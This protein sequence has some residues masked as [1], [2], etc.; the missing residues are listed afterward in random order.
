MINSD[1]CLALAFAAHGPIY[2]I[3]GVCPNM[4]IWFIGFIGF[5]RFV[6]A[7]PSGFRTLGWLR[8]LLAGF[9]RFARGLS[10]SGFVVFEVDTPWAPEQPLPA[11]WEED[12]APARGNLF[13]D[14]S[15]NERVGQ[16]KIVG[17]RELD[18]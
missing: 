16:T 10:V 6:W 8:R 3:I 13:N 2:P 18:I 17:A 1:Y 12:W 14:W 9:R 7:S 11:C 5:N 15:R 4:P